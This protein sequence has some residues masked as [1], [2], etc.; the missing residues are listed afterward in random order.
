MVCLWHLFLGDGEEFQMERLFDAHALAMSF[1]SP[2][3]VTSTLDSTP[4]WPCHFEQS[5]AFENTREYAW[6]IRAFVPMAL[7]VASVETISKL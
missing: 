4:P 1:R 2:L 7:P 3:E 5:L 6:V